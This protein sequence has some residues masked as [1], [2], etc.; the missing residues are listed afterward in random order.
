MLLLLLLLVGLLEM[1]VG[2]GVS[3]QQV[4]VV[5]HRVDLGDDA[6][7]SVARHVLPVHLHG[8]RSSYFFSLRNF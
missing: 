7:V 8:I 6:V 1:V 5:R 3:D 2:L 4:R